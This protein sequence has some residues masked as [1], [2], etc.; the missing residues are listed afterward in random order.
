MRYLM[1]ILADEKAWASL[2]KKEME[3]MYQQY[4]AYSAELEKAVKVVAGDE[5]EPT[6]KACRIRVRE[7]KPRVTDGPFTET[8]EVVGGY[9]VFDAG[10]REEAIRIAGRCPGAAHGAIELYPIKPMG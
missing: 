7:G 4:G 1:L 8:K 3:A 5:L 9:Y 2:P 6:G 10:T